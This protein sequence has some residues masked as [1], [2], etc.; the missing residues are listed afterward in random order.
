MKTKREIL[1]DKLRPLVRSI[2][3]EE[4]PGQKIVWKI[5]AY[6][7]MGMKGKE[8]RKTF[9]NP[10]QLADWVDRNDAEVYG[11]RYLKN[12]QPVEF[13]DTESIPDSWKGE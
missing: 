4:S 2:L 1:E 10:D 9:S 3:K 13:G 7:I 8:W 6:G 5:E 11:S 12:G